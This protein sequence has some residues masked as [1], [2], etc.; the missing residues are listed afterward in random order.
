MSRI[1]LVSFDDLLHFRD[2]AF[3]V[4]LYLPLGLA[5]GM[6]PGGWARRGLIVVGLLLAPAI[7]L[8]QLLVRPLGRACQ[9]SDM[10]D[11]ITGL[12]IGLVAGWLIARA[13]GLYRSD[14][15]QPS[16]VETSSASAT[17][18]P[19]APPPPRPSDG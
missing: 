14:P 12:L 10:S 19:A 18:G 2:P 4:A 11:N 13:I 7:E 16:A 8:T 6:L 5:I 17:D 3:N 15:D 1:G 9:T